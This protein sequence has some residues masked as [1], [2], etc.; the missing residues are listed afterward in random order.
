MGQAE[1]LVPRG[2]DK[3]LPSGGL[4]ASVTPDNPKDDDRF[5]HQD[6]R[7]VACHP[8]GKW[9]PGLGMSLAPRASIA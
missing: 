5:A 3:S 1:I 8:E 4:A 6:G 2:G 9:D 7:K